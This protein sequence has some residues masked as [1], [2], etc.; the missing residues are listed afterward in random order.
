VER[1]AGAFRGL[2]ALVVLFPTLALANGVPQVQLEK[3]VGTGP[4]CPEPNHSLQ[5]PQGTEV[6]YCYVVKNTGT[7]S[8]TADALH[9]NVLGDIPGTHVLAPGQ[10]FTETLLQTATVPITNTATITATY[11]T[12]VIT[13]DD[14]DMLT[15][16]TASQNVSP[17]GEL[18]TGT[19]TTQS[20]PVQ[21]CVA[22]PQGGDVSI[23]VSQGG[24]PSVSGFRM[25]GF[26]V[27]ITAP[28]ATVAN[29]LVLTFL[30]DRTLVPQNLPLSNMDVFDNGRLVPVCTGAPKAIPDPCVEARQLLGNGDVQI[31]VLTSSANASIWCFATLPYA[32]VPLLSTTPQILLIGLLVLV[33]LFG[34]LRPVL[35]R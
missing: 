12:G 6:K 19:A 29:P 4:T 32:P 16:T 1:T 24:C 18:C 23:I 22:T 7:V 3:T 33:G 27:N 25:L 21:A 15:I 17:G 10:S 5:V 30:L 35:K 28:P 11:S 20:D 31:T 2:V 14:T 13:S 34:V 8:I 9:D 26:S